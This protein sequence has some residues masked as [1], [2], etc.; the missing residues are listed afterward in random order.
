MSSSHLATIP[1]DSY[2][3]SVSNNK[4]SAS[5]HSF[6]DG[7][8]KSQTMK[9]AIGRQGTGVGSALEYGI[10]GIRGPIKGDAALSLV[11]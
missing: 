1:P 7:S 11:G 9:E 2:S 8:Q 4:G 10:Q 3:L 6:S 5:S